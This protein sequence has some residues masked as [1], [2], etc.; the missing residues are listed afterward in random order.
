M[1]RPCLI[2]LYIFFPQMFQ[3]TMLIFDPGE[4]IE[5]RIES[6]LVKMSQ[7]V[8]DD[9]RAVLQ[10]MLEQVLEK[11]KVSQAQSFSDLRSKY[12]AK[13]KSEPEDVINVDESPEAKQSKP[14]RN[15]PNV[16]TNTK[17]TTQT[18]PT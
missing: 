3:A 11:N 9:E 5:Q 2:L 17:N 15:I 7:D 10:N 6:I 8:T 16:K 13:K 12:G 4:T 18:K 1:S 14:K